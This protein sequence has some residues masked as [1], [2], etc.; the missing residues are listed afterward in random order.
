MMMRNY[1]LAILLAA[2]S[3]IAAALFCGGMLGVY[4]DLLNVFL[5][6]LFPLAYQWILFGKNF[7]K[8]AFWAP[9]KKEP[10]LGELTKSQVFFKSY[11]KVT[12]ITALIVIIIA[13]V[14]MLNFLEDRSALGPTMSLAFLG[15][16]YAGLIDILIIVPYTIVLKK[17]MLLL[18]EEIQ[19]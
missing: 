3:F 9:F 10:S 7:V 13:L 18:D 4:I 1:V 19:V 6:I 11:R 5:I 2:F 15:M 17:R 14:A 8:T 12:W 16:L